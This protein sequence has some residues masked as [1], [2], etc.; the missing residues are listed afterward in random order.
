MY[1]LLNPAK[2]LLV[3]TKAKS[4]PRQTRQKTTSGFKA[5]MTLVMRLLINS[6][7]INSPLINSPVRK[8]SNPWQRP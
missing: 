4:Y 7:L 1:L 6:S 2:K 5:L 3:E 8:Y